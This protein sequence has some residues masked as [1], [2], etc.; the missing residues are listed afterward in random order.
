[1]EQKKRG[2]GRNRAEAELRWGPTTQEGIG[3]EEVLE[4][5]TVIMSEE[6]RLAKRAL[7]STCC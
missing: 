1:M 7:H 2:G 6:T 5:I 4:F 3:R